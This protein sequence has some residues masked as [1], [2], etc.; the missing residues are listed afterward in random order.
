MKCPKCGIE[1][2]LKFC[3][4]CHGL[5]REPFIEK[6]EF[7]KKEDLVKKGVGAYLKNNNHSILTKNY[8]AYSLIFG[9]FY[10]SYY[11]LYKTTLLEI[12]LDVLF[13]S[14]ILSGHIPLILLPFAP[15]WSWFLIFIRYLIR[16][17]LGNT[18]MALEIKSKVRKMIDRGYSI[19]IIAI[20][21]RP[22]IIPVVFSI[23]MYV[24]IFIVFF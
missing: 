9:S 10:T 20:K 13:I 21:G 15:F 5:I 6:D 22:N 2:D 3:P 11:K 23:S 12:V 17:I 16:A 14:Y 18:L 8:T 24:L 7:E 19:D 4:K 1:T